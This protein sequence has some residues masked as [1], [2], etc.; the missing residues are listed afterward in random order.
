MDDRRLRE[1][2]ARAERLYQELEHFERC[3]DDLAEA[4]EL[5]RTAP[6]GGTTTSGSTI[7]A[8]EKRRDDLL[9]RTG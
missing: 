8:W 9:R 7:H 6:V 4:R 5:L 3:Q 1:A 2:V